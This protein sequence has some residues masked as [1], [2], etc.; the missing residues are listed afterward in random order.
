DDHRKLVSQ[1]GLK[2][3]IIVPLRANDRVLGAISL[4]I[5]EGSRRYDEDDLASAEEIAQRAAIALDN[6]RLYRDAQRAQHTAEE[7]ATRISRLQNLTAALSESLTPAE[8]A[9]VIINQGLNVLDAV[10]GSVALLDPDRSTIR[11]INSIGYDAE[12]LETWR[13]F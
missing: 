3:S 8:V 1:I 11:V 10:A 5:S 6:A 13:T 2:S 4:A 9:S 12:L 7:S